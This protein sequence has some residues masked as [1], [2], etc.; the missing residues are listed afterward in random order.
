MVGWAGLKGRGEARGGGLSASRAC[1]TA[2]RVLQLRRPP[3]NRPQGSACAC[4]RT[5]MNVCTPPPYQPCS[6]KPTCTLHPAGS[7]CD[8]RA[9]ARGRRRGSLVLAAGRQGRARAHMRARTPSGPLPA[10]ASRCHCPPPP[11]LPP[12][13]PPGHPQPTA[14]TSS[15]SMSAST[16]RN[17]SSCR[18]CSVATSSASYTSR[19]ER[20]SYT[21]CSSR[22]R[23]A[24]LVRS[25][26]APGPPSASMRRS[27]TDR[28]LS[29]T[30]S[31]MSAV[32]RRNC[33]IFCCW[34]D[35][36]AA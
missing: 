15:S 35:G 8:A 7:R 23:S 18:R 34:G 27:D 19:S 22:S 17:T 26:G 30:D 11:P 2:A 4:A 25:G 6:A 20:A 33:S 9:C 13:P 16:R 29:A 5:C 36:G 12:R 24:S 28:G 3:P 14:R 10:P 32:R 21:R 31:Y 1:G